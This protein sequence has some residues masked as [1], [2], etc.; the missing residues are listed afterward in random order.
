MHFAVLGYFDCFMMYSLPTTKMTLSRSLQVSEPL[1]TSDKSRTQS[2]FCLT[3]GP[4]PSPARRGPALCFPFLSTQRELSSA[5]RQDDGGEG[6]LGLATDDA[7]SGTASR[8][9]RA[10]CDARLLR[11]IRRT[12]LTRASRKSEDPSNGC[13]C[14]TAVD[15]GVC[16]EC[17][18]RGEYDGWGEG[19]SV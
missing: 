13:G 16:G 11:S 1:D 12:L 18:R 9:C 17:G 10:D 15:M 7:S 19:R 14:M 2:D 4:R 5:G 8:T 3:T 6:A